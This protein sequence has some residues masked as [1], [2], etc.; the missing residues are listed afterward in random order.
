MFASR[1]L[2]DGF[3]MSFVRQEEKLSVGEMSCVDRLVVVCESANCLFIQL[4][5]SQVCQQV[6]GRSSKGG[7]CSLNS[8]F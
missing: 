7:F 1:E 2:G 8:S 5:E 4:G 6:Y 3:Q